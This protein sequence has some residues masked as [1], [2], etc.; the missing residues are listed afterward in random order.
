VKDRL[1]AVDELLEHVV[2]GGC[3]DIGEF[4]DGGAG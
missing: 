3:R 1:K 2:F 4:V